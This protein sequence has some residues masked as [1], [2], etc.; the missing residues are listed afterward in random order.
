MTESFANRTETNNAMTRE[1]SNGVSWPGTDN[2]VWKRHQDHLSE[3]RPTDSTG[4]RLGN[5]ER[6]LPPQLTEHDVLPSFART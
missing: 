5:E 1:H 3:R 6:Q 4:K 2:R